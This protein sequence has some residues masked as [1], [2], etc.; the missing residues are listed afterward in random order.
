MYAMYNDQIK[1]TDIYITW[2]LLNS[3]TMFLYYFYQF[4]L[5][6]Y[7][8][9]NNYCRLFKK[10]KGMDIFYVSGSSSVS[11]NIKIPIPQARSL[12]GP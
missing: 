1:I 3:F 7:T 12:S 11:E 10:R 4:S 5:K 8:W 6:S 2:R 9:I